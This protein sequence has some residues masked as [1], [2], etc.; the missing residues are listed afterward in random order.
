MPI[1]QKRKS[2]KEIKSLVSK[3]KRKGRASSTVGHKGLSRKSKEEAVKNMKQFAYREKIYKEYQKAPKPK[4]S[5][6]FKT[7]AKKKAAKSIAKG[8]AGKLVPP[9][10][11]ALAATEVYKAGKKGLKD[12]KSRKSCEKKGG[13][14]QKGY[15]ITRSSKK[16]K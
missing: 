11:I 10:G 6:S 1:K 7:A 14:W 12:R 9:L 3:I 2:P 4:F 13:I 16:K 15:C 5:K 8:V